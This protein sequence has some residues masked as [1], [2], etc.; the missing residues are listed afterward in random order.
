MLSRGF[1]P[2]IA[3]SVR[4]AAYEQHSLPVQTEVLLDTRHG[5][6]FC[7]Y[8]HC[9][10]GKHSASEYYPAGRNAGLACHD[11]G[12]ELEQHCGGYLGWSLRILPALSEIFARGLLLD[13]GRPTHKLFQDGPGS[14]EP[15]RGF[16]PCVRP[17]PGIRWSLRL[18]GVSPGDSRFGDQYATRGSSEDSP[19]GP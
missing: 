12:S 19:A 15:P 14:G 2:G 1:Q 4:F 7:G 16:L 13:S 6:P 9:L 3:E 5:L 11:G 10:R 18:R 17:Y 8:T